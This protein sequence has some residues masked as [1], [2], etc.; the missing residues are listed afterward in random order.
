MVRRRKCAREREKRVQRRAPCPDADAAEASDAE[1]VGHIA[2]RRGAVE[3]FNAAHGQC[4]I[5]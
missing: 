5:G 4:R 1:F 2:K 3:E